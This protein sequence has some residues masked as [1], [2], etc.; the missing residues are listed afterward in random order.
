MA[1]TTLSRQHAAARPDR[2]ANGARPLHRRRPLPGGRAVVGGFLV[3]AAAVGVFAGYTGATADQREPYLV[4]RRDLSLGHRITKADLA[5]LP[6]DLPALLRSKVYRDPSKLVGALVIGPVTKGELVQASAVLAGAGTGIPDERQI[7]FPIESARA[8]NGQLH[9]GEFVDVLATYG[10]GTEG[11]T[12]AVVR[13]ARVADRSD[14]SGALS[15][16]GNEV[17]TLSVPREADTLAVA[18]A[19]SAGTVILV[20]STAPVPAGDVVVPS[21]PYQPAA[22]PP[23]PAVGGAGTPGSGAPAGTG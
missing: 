3:A 2:G 8:V 12:S 7:S 6:M 21:T 17:I 10:T 16:R 23:E 11:Y 15:D 5:T 13:G 1:E 22:G 9:L 14:T 18:H 4:A 20:R 19:V